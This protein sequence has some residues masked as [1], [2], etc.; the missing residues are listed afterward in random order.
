MNLITFVVTVYFTMTGP[1]P[2]KYLVE[3][4]SCTEAQH[5]LYHVIED[6][7]PAVM[8]CDREDT[9]GAVEAIEVRYYKPLGV[10][11]TPLLPVP[12]AR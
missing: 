5:I 4:A 7:E 12:E 10:I 8:Y 6:Q 9:N 3:A 2:S 1:T 11:N